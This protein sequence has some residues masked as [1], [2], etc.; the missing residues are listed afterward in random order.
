LGNTV[1]AA[2]AEFVLL[3][4]PPFD[5]TAV[6]KKT[7][8]ETAEDF[9]SSAPFSGYNGVLAEYA[10]WQ[11]TLSVEDAKVVVDLH[12]ALTTALASRREQDASFT[13]AKDGI[14]PAPLG[15][16]L[17]AHTFLRG[18]GVEPGD[19]ANDL[20][21]EQARVEADPL[22]KRVHERREKRSAGWLSF[23]GYNRGKP[24]KTDSVSAVEADVEALKKQIDVLRR[25]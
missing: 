4:P 9:G 6:P 24:V 3:T 12:G 11:Q 23:I 18:I 5:A 8:P 13:F 10:K 2:E 16:L 21:S 20:D 17:M 1:R 15:H 22:F 19:A 14:H 7:Q 25:Q